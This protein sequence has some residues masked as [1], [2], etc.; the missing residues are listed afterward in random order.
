MSKKAKS[1]LV[2]VIVALC[3]VL[4]AVLTVFELG[5]TYRMVKAIEVDGTE[6]SVAEYNWLYTNNLYEIY[7]QYYQTYGEMTPY[8]IN[9]QGKLSEQVYNKETGETWADYVKDYTDKTFVEMTALYN[10]GKEA[11]YELDADYLEIIE[12]E[13]DS[14]DEIATAN[15]YTAKDYAEINYGRGVNEKVFK[16]MYER[17]YY[18]F[19][20]AE[21]I[22]DEI[23]VSEADIDA[24]YEENAKE[25][26]TVSY[27]YYF[28]NGIA[29]EGEDTET[30]MADAKAEA[31]AI[32]A[33][34]ETELNSVRYS[35][36]AELGTTYADW[37]FDEARVSG[38][39]DIFETSSGYYVIE[40]VERNDIHYNTV[41]VRHILVTPEDTESASA[42]E[43]ALVLAET[44]DA[45]WK[46]LGGSEENFAETA[47]K[48]SADG[49]AANGGLYENVFKGQMVTEFEDWC[50][51]PAR[52]AGD[53][54]II[55]TQ[56]GYHIMYFSGVAEEYYDFIIGG[57]VRSERL[58]AYLDEITEGIE[59]VAKSGNKEVGK[60]LG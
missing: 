6:Y 27:N 51:D 26:D 28:V 29:T 45:E 43:E 59:V 7:N 60:H 49:S 5:V 48:Y 44:Y 19:T 35:T 37:L 1:T 38:D 22:A 21:K 9:P 36:Y 32:L 53:T 10:E 56:F 3:V 57:T 31:E 34:N 55:K 23:E 2:K 30:A 46:E 24:R 39:K 4:C 17:Y 16:E 58:N 41:D 14:M 42:W 18:A 54:E 40:F 11:G 50:F 15:G 47:K 13:W 25:F 33:G 8:I 20:Y 12:N 52:K